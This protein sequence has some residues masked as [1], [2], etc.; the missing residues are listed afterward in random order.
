MSLTKAHNRMIE[1]SAVNVKDFGAVGDGVTDDTAAIQAAIDANK[2]GTVIIPDGTYLHAGVLLNDSSYNN[3]SLIC[4][5]ILK[6]KAD[7]GASIFGGSWGGTLIKDC[8]GITLE[9]KGD[10]NRAAMTARE[11]IFLVGIAGASDINIR[12][13]DAVDI[14][15][16]GLYISQSDWASNSTVPSNI[17]IGQFYAKNSAAGD[18]R[19]ALSVISVD[20][21]HI[22][23]FVSIDVGGTINSVVQPGGLDI[24][25]NFGYQ[26][27]TDITISGGYIRSGGTSGFAILGKA[28]T[29][30]ATR[31]W[32]C[33]N[34]TAKLTNVRTGTS[35]SGLAAAG[36][37]RC[38]DIMVDLKES[39]ATTKGKAR[40]IDRADNI[41]GVLS[42]KNVTN[43]VELGITDKVTDF[44]LQIF[45]NTYNNSAIKTTE[46]ENG[47]LTGRVYDAVGGASFAIECNAAGRG[48][49]SQSNVVYSVDAPYGNNVRA[50]RNEPSAP[51]TFV[52]CIV[53][54]C[55]FS[56]YASVSVTNDAQILFH[57]VEGI[58]SAAA[59]P[60]S[61]TWAAGQIVYN[62][63]T[64]PDANGMYQ[65]GWTRLTSGNSNVAGTDWIYRY[66]STVSPAI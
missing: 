2:G 21:L 51:V 25:P 19:N 22:G 53:Q 47:R 64:T 17:R 15:G 50:F 49:I 34:I 59:I 30:D 12:S 16:D 32:N 36:L 65:E 5:G 24:E 42:C 56:G 37:T 6:L 1:G 9:Y 8:S 4:R 54:N 41:K 33:Y 48:A 38:R 62:K 46:I 14:R 66:V 57:N 35:G 39:Y 23:S 60:S 11:Q 29:N 43:G 44:D 31:D 55:N 63:G 58:T 27:C 28:I 18:G 3:T 61:G 20:K 52:K 7:G 10:G 26:T 13:F 45:V 40:I